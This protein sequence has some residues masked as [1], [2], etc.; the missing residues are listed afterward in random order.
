MGCSQGDLVIEPGQPIQELIFVI[1]G[2]LIAQL[3]EGEH[4]T[5][6]QSCVRSSGGLPEPLLQQCEVELGSGAWLGEMCLFEECVSTSVAAAVTESE[7]AVLPA[8]E[9]HRVIQKFPN[10]LQRHHDITR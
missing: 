1:H 10:L 3:C 6:R 2:R 7:L 4:E 9:F 8:D 5:T